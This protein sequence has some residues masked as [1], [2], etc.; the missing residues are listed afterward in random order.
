[1]RAIPEF[2]FDLKEKLIYQFI[3]KENRIELNSRFK[4]L[5]V[6]PKIVVLAFPVMCHASSHFSPWIR[7]F[8]ELSPAA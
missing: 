2:I 6:F 1:M 5:S 3:K 8:D 4:P 7:G